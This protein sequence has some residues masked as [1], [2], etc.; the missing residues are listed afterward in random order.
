MCSRWQTK[1]NG[2][3]KHLNKALT[4]WLFIMQL[5]DC[6]VTVNAEDLGW[7]YHNIFFSDGIESVTTD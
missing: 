2:N 5:P 6:L 4:K 7:F 1:T 3:Q